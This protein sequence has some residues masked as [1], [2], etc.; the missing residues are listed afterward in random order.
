MDEKTIASDPEAKVEAHE[1]GHILTNIW[2]ESVIH[3][4]N[5][6]RHKHGHVLNIDSNIMTEN[7]N[8]TVFTNWQCEI[9][10]NHPL[11]YK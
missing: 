7:V 8:S 3:F 4:N 9:M 6:Y 5:I 11:V 1:L 2:D 10:R